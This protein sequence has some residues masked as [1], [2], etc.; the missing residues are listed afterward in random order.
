MGDVVDRTGL[1]IDAPELRLEVETDS[2][3][4]GL[5]K[6]VRRHMQDSVRAVE[7][8]AE[9]IELLAQNFER[10]TLGLILA[11]QKA[12][13]GHSS[14]LAV[15]MDAPNAL[16][17]PLRIPRQIVVDQRVAKLQVQAL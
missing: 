12:H 15:A 10:E 7:H 16:L 13:H 14:T 1:V 5:W 4:E 11:R 2:R 17:N 9:Q 6:I 3:D 8:L